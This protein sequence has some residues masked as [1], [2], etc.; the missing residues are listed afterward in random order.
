MKGLVDNT[1]IN[2]DIIPLSKIEMLENIPSIKTIC[3]FEANNS[4]EESQLKYVLKLLID[5]GVISFIFFG[6][7]E[8]QLHD[9]ADD[10]IETDYMQQEIVTDG[11]IETDY[12]QQEIV[13]ATSLGDKGKDLYDFFLNAMYFE[14]DEYRFLAI[15]NEASANFKKNSATLRSMFQEKLNKVGEDN[16]TG[17]I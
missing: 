6:K 11:V 16:E 4:T 2:L 17:K 9:I 3:L 15:M 13:T 5:K 8:E 7:F 12:M 1:K 10:V 14:N